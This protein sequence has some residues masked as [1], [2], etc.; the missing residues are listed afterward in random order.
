MSPF[1]YTRVKC[2]NPTTCLTVH[3]QLGRFKSEYQALHFKLKEVSPVQHGSATLP[4]RK[5]TSIFTNFTH[6]LCDVSQDVIQVF[7]HR[8]VV[9][10]IM[11]LTRHSGLTCSL[12]RES[13]F[14]RW[15]HNA[16]KP[17]SLFGHMNLQ[18]WRSL[19]IVHM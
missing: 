3:L 16:F 9:I 6:A 18:L 19:R 12:R 8:R 2:I 1:K 13:S 17:C 7:T 5:S 4:I 15:P 14:Y 11:P 10:T